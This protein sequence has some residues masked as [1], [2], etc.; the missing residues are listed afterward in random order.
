M[1]SLT[2]RR[3][4]KFP[5]LPE[6]NG[7]SR[8]RSFAGFLNRS[9]SRKESMNQQ[10]T[11]TVL[12]QDYRV[13]AHRAADKR[14]KSVKAPKTPRPTRALTIIDSLRSGLKE[15]ILLTNDDM[16]GLTSGNERICIQNSQQLKA[17]DRYLK[18]L[19]LQL[20]KLEELSEN[21]V[22]QC[23]LREGVRSMAQAYRLSTGKERDSALGKVKAGYKEC[24]QNMCALEAQ[25]EQMMGSLEMRMKGIAGFARLCPGD[26][27]EIIIR[28]GPQ[29]WKS[30][31]TVNKDAT[32]TWDHESVIFKSLL[33][34]ILHVKASEVRTLGNRVIVGNKHCETKDLFSAHHQIMTISLN[35]NGSLKLNLV[36]TWNP[37]D[38][39]ADDFIWSPWMLKA[40]SEPFKLKKPLS[41]VNSFASSDRLPSLHS[42]SMKQALSQR[43]SVCSTMSI[44]SDRRSSTSPK[45]EG[46]RNGSSSPSNMSVVSGHNSLETVIRSVMTALEEFRDHYPQLSKLEEQILRIEKMLLPAEQNGHF[47]RGSN[48]SISVESALDCFDFLND[49]EDSDIGTVDRKLSSGIRQKNAD[50]QRDTEGH[51]SKTVDSGIES[52]EHNLKSSDEKLSPLRNASSGCEQID[53]ALIQHLLY[54]DTLLE[55][56]GS[57]GP[58]KYGENRAIRHLQTQTDILEI[59]VKLIADPVI[60]DD[61][62]TLMRDITEKQRLHLLWEQ[63]AGGHY[64]NTSADSVVTQ[65]KARYVHFLK[66]FTETERQ[67]VLELLICQMLDR[68]AY[69]PST[70]VTVFHFLFF[71]KADNH[72][73]VEALLLKFCNDLKVLGSLQSKDINEVVET[74]RSLRG[75]P[76]DAAY[77]VQIAVCLLND[78]QDVQAAARDF[79]MTSHGELS[80]RNWMLRTYS[81]ALEDDRTEIRRGACR[82]LGVLKATECVEELIHVIEFDSSSSVKDEAKEVLVSLGEPGRQALSSLQPA[83][84]VASE[85][86]LRV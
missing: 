51:K 65:L 70:I 31:G 13:L 22:V 75:R 44:C 38:G 83:K 40:S 28:H 77:A 86:T 47:S 5:E 68:P 48:L 81:T 57:S 39:V 67:D 6:G 49:V 36:I 26:V 11:T 27:F 15:C 16:K 33:G 59:F 29:K 73:D 21:Y 17:A 63:C 41:T 60:L 14:M 71:L 32:Q 66:T 52:L 45:T 84:I 9:L 55:S 7:V 53:L 12:G 69:D 78:N 72:W 18:R 56:L 76:V 10:S 2:D 25:L 82:A 30:R 20:S 79:L 85:F 58:L 46:S 35:S 3:R 61:F 42:A 62:T 64:L 50:I 4:L 54:C 80:L 1:S 24:T 23:K 74:L 37:L 8:S 34:D 43:D 19:E